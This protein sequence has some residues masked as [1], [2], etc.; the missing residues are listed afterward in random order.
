MQATIP[1]GW[2]DLRK[3]KVPSKPTESTDTDNSS[4]SGSTDP[5]GTTDQT[6]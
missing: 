2:V 3:P 6:D 4:N 5:D 1:D